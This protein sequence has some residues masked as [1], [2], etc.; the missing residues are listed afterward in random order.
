MDSLGESTD[1]LWP[2]MPEAFSEIVRPTIFLRSFDV[3]PVSTIVRDCTGL[4]VSAV[5]RTSFGLYIVCR[6]LCDGYELY[7]SI[8]I[9]FL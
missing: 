1:C 7:L 6:A 9:Q 4:D 5:Q 2:V 3:P 8:I